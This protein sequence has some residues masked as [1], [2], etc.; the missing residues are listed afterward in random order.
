MRVLK[1]LALGY[2]TP[3]I[4]RDLHVSVATVRSHVQKIYKKLGAH[5]RVEALRIA[6]EGGMI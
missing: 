2:E 1:L 3:R 6:E 5:N 4:A